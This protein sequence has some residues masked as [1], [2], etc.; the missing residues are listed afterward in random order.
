[1]LHLVVVGLLASILTSQ[2]PAT[3]ARQQAPPLRIVVL[4]GEDAVN[5]I[6]QK[7]AV[8]PLIEVRDRNNIP[9]AGATVTFSVAQGASFGGL[10]T[11][12]V[13]TNAA[14]Q[15]LAAGLT[16]TVAGSIQIQ[17]TAIFQGQTAIATIAQ[18][19]VVTLA[20]AAAAGSSGAAGG[21]SGGGLSGTTLGVAGAAVGAAVIG[22][23]AAT[24]GDPTPAAPQVTASQPTAPQPTAPQPTPTTQV[25]ITTEYSGAVN[26]QILLQTTATAC[27]GG[28]TGCQYTL[29]DSGTLR[30]NLTRTPGD[31]VTG[32]AALTRFTAMA[33]TACEITFIGGLG[34]TPSNTASKGWSSTFNGSAQ[35]FGFDDTLNENWIS[36]NGVYSG[37]NTFRRVFRGSLTDGVISGTLTEDFLTE[38]TA[39]GM[40][41]IR[42]VAQRVIPVTVR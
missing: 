15:A 40:C 35:S 11:L 28:F 37:T 14:G 9:V 17:A 21:S 20:Q 12:T 34:N 41:R 4:A 25:P 7:T 36:P 5:V 31:V 33:A 1:M 16:P 13:T 38:Y 26:G 30:V 42:E 29:N 10:S 39:F 23:V 2:P 24:G 19:N 8:S 27:G 6:Q 3:V 22:V 32:T 18:S